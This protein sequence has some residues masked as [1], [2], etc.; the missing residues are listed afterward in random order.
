MILKV[1]FN[2]CLMTRKM[3][4]TGK[5]FIA[6]EAKLII[7][8]LIS[9]YEVKLDNSGLGRIPDPFDQ[10]SMA[11]VRLKVSKRSEVREARMSASLRELH[12]NNKKFLFF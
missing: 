8:L 11:G 1:K 9:R 4:V 12:D 2:P 7:A 6:L 5:H 3:Y 10:T